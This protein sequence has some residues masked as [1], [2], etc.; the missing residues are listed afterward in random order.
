MNDLCGLDPNL[1]F[2]IGTKGLII[3]Y[4]PLTCEV[5][6]KS[7]KFISMNAFRRWESAEQVIVNIDGT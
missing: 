6:S 3:T 5:D 7:N 4:T 2:L 1:R